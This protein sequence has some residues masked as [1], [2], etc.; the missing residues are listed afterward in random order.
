M[1]DTSLRFSCDRGSS[2]RR[3]GANG[4]ER[5]SGVAAATRI[6]PHTRT[7]AIGAVTPPVWR[8]LS[9][10]TAASSSTVVLTVQA[11]SD[12]IGEGRQ[13]SRG[14]G[15]DGAGLRCHDRLM[16]RAAVLL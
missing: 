10:P 8:T 13:T 7:R 5:C 15:L 16:P 14:R 11:A 12:S 1:Y 4:S 2:R 6:R 3:A 9:V